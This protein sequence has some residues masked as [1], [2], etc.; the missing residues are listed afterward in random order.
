MRRENQKNAESETSN[1]SPPILQAFSQT[2]FCFIE[3]GVIMC[4]TQAEIRKN[5]KQIKKISAEKIHSN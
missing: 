1:C 2:A 4:L 5:K 3:V